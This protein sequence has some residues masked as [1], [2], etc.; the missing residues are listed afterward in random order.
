MQQV[1]GILRI[2]KKIWHLSFGLMMVLSHSALGLDLDEFSTDLSGGIK[3]EEKKEVPKTEG[4]NPNDPKL[5]TEP[6]EDSEFEKIQV[7]G[8]HIKRLKINGASPIQVLDRQAMEKSGYNSVSDVLRDLSANSF[9]ST[10][11]QSGSS[12]AGVATVSLRGL[13]SNKTLVLLNGKRL[14][15]DAVIG[16]V[17]L[18]LI[19]MAAVQKIEILKDGASAT[20]GSDALGGV[21]NIIT[22]KDYNGSELTLQKNMVTQFN[23]GDSHQVG[24]ITGSSTARSSV[25]TVINYR[26]NEKFFSKDRPWTKDGVSPTGSPGAFKIE[27]G[28]WQPASNCTTPLDQGDGDVTCAY[29]FAQFS[30]ELPEIKQFSGMTLFEYETD[31]SVT[32]FGRLNT[33]RKLVNWQYAP[34]PGTFSV[35]AGSPIPELG[36]QAGQIRYRTVDLGNRVTEVETTSLGYQAGAKGSLSTKWDWEFTF[37]QNRVRDMQIG[38]SGYALSSVLRNLIQTG[39]FNPLSGEGVEKLSEAFYQPWQS[40]I[41]NNSMYELKFT[42]ELFDMSGGVAGAAAGLV[43]TEDAY[44]NTTDHL[45]ASGKVFS[46]GGSSGGG[47]RNAQS[48]YVEFIL[49]VTKKF[50]VQIAGRYDKFNDFGDTT[51]PKLGLSYNLTDKWML[52][53][54]GG[55]G[56]MAPNLTDLY[57]AKSFGFPTFTDAVACKHQKDTNVPGT[58]ACTPQQYFVESGGNPNLKQEE[59]VSVNVGTVY[60]PTSNFRTSLDVWSTQLSNVVSIDYNQLMIAEMRGVNL[61]QYGVIVDRDPVTKR[62]TDEKGVIAPLQNLSRQDLSGVDLQLTYRT[63]FGLYFTMDHSMMFFYKEEGFPGTGFRDSLEENGRPAWRNSLNIGFSKEKNNVNMLLRTIGPHEKFV[64]EEGKLPAYTEVDLSYNRDIFSKT[65]MTVGVQN[66]LST[67]A[68]LDDSNPNSKM[69]TSLYNP[70]GQVVFAA[71]KQG[72]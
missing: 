34:A 42:G 68:P 18:N 32:L 67:I 33:S 38:I 39:E 63:N 56:F 19:P 17:D 6:E 1:I 45:S 59:S 65:T 58:P 69:L 29:N 24:F 14:P 13:G 62:I 52:R 7:T 64:P 12:A 72:F 2:K 5:A 3:S 57:A 50:E 30:S 4:A 41:S 11:E 43:Y 26:D 23:G 55:T 66:L 54:S 44:Q 21:V 31:S 8:S 28:K 60:Q 16:S 37:D 48:A 47:D 9:G 49:P 10:R 46:N 22:Y 27:G 61:A 36:G 70:R 20:Y 25:V 15:I 51:N 71:L 35:D 53:A 40:A